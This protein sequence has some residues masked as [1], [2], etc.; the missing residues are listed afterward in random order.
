MTGGAGGGGAPMTASFAAQMNTKPNMMTFVSITIVMMGALMFG[1][2]QNNFGLVHGMPS[3]CEFWCPKF[4]FEEATADP[5][6]CSNLH[7]L[8]VADQ[9]ADWITFNAFGLNMVPMGMAL[10][11]LT[12]APL[13]ARRWG[14]RLTI[15]L[16]GL[17]C[18]LGCIIVSYISTNVTVYMIGRFFTGYGCGIACY[19]LPMYQSEVA[20][21]G[22]RGLMG[23]LFQLMVVLG[24]VLA[25][26]LLGVIEDWKQGFM[27]PGYAGFVVGLAVWLC[28]E[29][30]RFV[31]DRFGKDAGR[32]VLQRVRR[33]DVETELEFLDRNLQEEKQA[34]SIP[35]SQLFTK[36][37]LR[38][39][40]FTACYLQA[41]QQFTGVNAFLGFQTDIFKAAGASEDAIAKVPNGP[42][43]LLQMTMLAGC[44]LG[45]VLVDSPVGGR[46]IQLNGAAV[47]MGPALII[48]AVA[49]WVG[50]SHQVTEIALF[51]F[52]FGFQLAWGIIP[53]F[54]PAELF[55]MREREAALSLSTFSGFAMNVVIGYIALPLL[56]WSPNGTFFIFGVLNVTNV[57]FVLACVKET[58][59][60]PL[61]DIP[62]LFGG[63]DVKDSKTVPFSQA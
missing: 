9:P 17:T 58:K 34:G 3:F 52:G 2:D 50:W 57:M 55:T 37:G 25:I 18:F 29:S 35:F 30:P 45:L 23:S 47:L 22:I 41:A 42:A 63:V 51:V 33:G 31:I 26:I 46:R 44:I 54:Y 48:G 38:L 12:L 20:T 56:R 27:L 59:G 4:D 5:A 1:I 24:G 62:A 39:R 40:V 60:V 6:F 36:P 49:G 7:R 16:G 11:C 14:R 28:P 61:E 13:C 8:D 15:S 19:C 32:P 10:G 53:W 21:I 43:F